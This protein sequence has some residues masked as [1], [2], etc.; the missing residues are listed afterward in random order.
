MKKYWIAAQFE[1]NG[2]MYAC[3]IPVTESDNLLSK[4][5]IK[6]IISANI[7]PTKKAAADLVLYWRKCYQENGNYM[8][9]DGP[10]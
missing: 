9:S 4:L 6:N 1:E 7:C 5:K 3:A 10:F 8:F 2:K